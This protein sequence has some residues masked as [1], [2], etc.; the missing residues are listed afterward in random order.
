LARKAPQAG[1]P[2]RGEDEPLETNVAILALPP[3][4]QALLEQTRMD[5]ERAV[6]ADINRVGSLLAGRLET[7]H[8]RLAQ[9][10]AEIDRIHAHTREIQKDP[11]NDLLRQARDRL[12]SM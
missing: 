1:A 11:L 7:I 3:E 4:A 8:Q 6:G 5:M 9:T 10:K 12:Q 2:A